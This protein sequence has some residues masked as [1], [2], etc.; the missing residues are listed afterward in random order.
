VSHE[1][2]KNHEASTSRQKSKHQKSKHQKSKHHGA[3]RQFPRR[4][5]KAK[6]QSAMRKVYRPIA[7]SRSGSL[8]SITSH[9]FESIGAQRIVIQ[10]CRFEVASS[11]V[12]AKRDRERRNSAQSVS[13]FTQIITREMSITF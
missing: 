12:V 4:F 2:P 13:L 10:L 5:C 9:A 6:H 3:I 11:L 7:K 1:K 8:K